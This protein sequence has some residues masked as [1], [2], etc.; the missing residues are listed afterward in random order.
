MKI[1]LIVACGAIFLTSCGYVSK[2]T[3]HTKQVEEAV[4]KSRGQSVE[5]PAVVLKRGV[6][7]LAYKHRIGYPPIP[8]GYIP[9]LL[10]K[11]TSI[12]KVELVPQGRG[13]DTYLTGLRGGETKVYYVNGM[14]SPQYS[15]ENIGKDAVFYRVLVTGAE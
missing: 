5:L 12:L 4:I 8:G 9:S 6:R 10:A 13:Y 1:M 11:D 2:S 7:T 14:V 15:R 3:L